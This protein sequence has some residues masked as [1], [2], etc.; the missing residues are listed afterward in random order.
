MFNKCLFLTVFI[1]IIFSINGFSQNFYDI[2][3]VNTIEINF[4]ESNWDDIL[5]SL[6][7]IGNKDRL[8]ANAVING[9][10]YDSVGVRY[11]GTSSYDPARAKNPF[12]IKLDHII[13]DQEIDGYGTLKLANVFKDPSFVREVLGYEIARKYMPASRAN[14]INVYVNGELV[15]LYTSV[16]SVDKSFL[17]SH[18]YSDENTFIKGDPGPGNP[19]ASLEYLGPDS[20][21]YFQSYEMKSDYGWQDL[22]DLCD[23]LNN[24]TSDIENVLNVDRLLWFM[25]YHNLLVSLDSPI[26]GPHNFYLYKDGTDRFNHI[27]WDLNMTFGTFTMRFGGPFQP[28]FTAT[29]LQQ[30]DPFHNIDNTSFPIINKILHIS[31]YRK[32]YIA[33]YKTLLEENISNGWYKSR[34][35][36][37]QNIID[38]DVQTDPNKFFTYNDF[39][40][41]ID[42]SIF[43]D[44]RQGNLIGISELMEARIN[45]LDNHQE[46]QYA[47]PVITDISNTPAIVTP[48][49]NVCI[50]VN[51][52]NAN[53]VMLAYRQTL[54]GK[55]VQAQMF[56]DGSHNDGAA[57]DGIYSVSISVGTNDVQYYIYAEN[58]DAAMF[59]PE[60]AEYEFYTLP[61]TGDVVINE[62]MADNDTTVADQDG[63]YDDWIELYNNSD[64]DKPLNGFFLS[65][66]GDDLT[67][68]TFP[69]TF[70]AANSYLIIWADN[71]EEQNGLHAN[72][73][74]SKSGEAIYLVFPD[75][76]I[77][78]ELTFGP[79]PT[80]LS[81]GRYPNG[82]GPFILMTPTLS[83]ENVNGVIGIPEMSSEMPGQ[84]SLSQNYP[85]PFNPSTMI[86]YELR[87]TNDV[88]ISIYNTLG[89]KLRTLVNT[90][91]PAGSYSVKW[92]GRDELGNQVASG[93]YFYKLKSGSCAEIKKMMLLR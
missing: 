29:E 72:F 20:T 51:V 52:D 32:I 25:A 85:N 89:Q 61:V 82:T 78:D 10:S 36:E 70:I 8:V 17:R 33:H 22:V 35:L 67:Q 79:Q 81:T 38:A 53:S 15:G 74:L 58:T 34:A 21:D 64:M 73:K 71:D 43:E 37:I 11:K 60:R 88:E 54:T 12:N 1:L 44:P 50:N 75:T 46:F 9:V 86:N 40:N 31:E 92:N 26:H 16:Q 14:F 65:D 24:Y 45:F 4:D 68:W 80:D 41:N 55:F 84:F 59:S 76:A 47:A 7:A 5:D 28:P 18:F 49:S 91:Q 93:M 42:N 48:N 77:V 3:A 90:K 57:G 66:D 2:N 69:D 19:G 6:Y 13:K 62:F 39:I 23:T 87:I 63:E 27:I 30:F 56:D 83:S